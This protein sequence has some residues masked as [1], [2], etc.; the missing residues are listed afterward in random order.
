[1]TYVFKTELFQGKAYGINDSWY[2]GNVNNTGAQIFRP[3]WKFINENMTRESDY[4]MDE[5]DGEYSRFSPNKIILKSEAM[6]DGIADKVIFNLNKDTGLISVVYKPGEEN[7]WA[8]FAEGIVEQDEYNPKY[9]IKQWLETFAIQKV[10]S[11]GKRK[12][13]KKKTRNVRK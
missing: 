13:L 7:A 8:N 9:N 12:T 10:S 6:H 11:G 5:L 1:M 4:T 2:T 3:F